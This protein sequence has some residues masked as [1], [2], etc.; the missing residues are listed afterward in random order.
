MAIAS[1]FGMIFDSKQIN[2]L[3]MMLQKEA[4]ISCL[5]RYVTI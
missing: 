1:K 3:E 4:L 5:L 2:K